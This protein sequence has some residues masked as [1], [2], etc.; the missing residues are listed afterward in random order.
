MKKFSPEKVVY[1]GVSQ[2]KLPEWI[3]SL[4]KGGLSEQEI[5]NII[6]A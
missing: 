2:E 6:S 4:E 3:E 1:G 5:E